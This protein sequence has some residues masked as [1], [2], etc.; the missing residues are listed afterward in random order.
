MTR[1][2]CAEEL[3]EAV[4]RVSRLVAPSHPRLLELERQLLA[5]YTQLGPQL[6]RP[7]R[8][9]RLQLLQRLQSSA[10]VPP[11]RQLEL[12]AAVLETQILNLV[13]DRA[14]GAAVDK[15]LAR[16]LCEKKILDVVRAKSK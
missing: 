5:A 9:R 15:L 1:S 3:E 13:Q 7:A 6:S 8:E 11:P 12:Q 2:S 14:G 16:K 10:A 4:W